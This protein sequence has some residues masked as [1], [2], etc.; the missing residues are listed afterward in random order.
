MKH[1]KQ[2]YTLQKI[3]I[4]YIVDSCCIS[5]VSDTDTV[6]TPRFDCPVLCDRIH[7]VQYSAAAHDVSQLSRLWCGFCEV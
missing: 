3:Y 6:M 4:Q 7:C 1:E 2:Q 5:T